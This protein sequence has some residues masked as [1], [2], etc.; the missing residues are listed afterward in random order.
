MGNAIVKA[1]KTGHSPTIEEG[2]K[3]PLVAGASTAVKS[4][5]GR[6]DGVHSPV[7]PASW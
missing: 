6:R 4:N 1:D 5:C 2:Q 3:L 7:P